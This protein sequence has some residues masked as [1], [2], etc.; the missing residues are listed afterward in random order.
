MPSE[1]AVEDQ[2]VIRRLKLLSTKRPDR[3]AIVAILLKEIG[4]PTTLLKCKP[5]KEFVFSRILRVL[6]KEML[7]I[8][9]PTCVGKWRDG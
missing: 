5:E 8:V 4:H 3:V 9:I 2:D 6:T 7:A 1:H